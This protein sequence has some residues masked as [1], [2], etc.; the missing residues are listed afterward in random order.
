MDKNGNLFFGLLEDDAIACWNI[1]KEY[2]TTN[3]RTVAQNHETMQAIA[4]LKVIENR[5][6]QEV[7][8]ILSCRF[9]VILI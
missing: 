4:G 5:H 2:T 6:G 3:I 1:G 8:W 7:L 9:H